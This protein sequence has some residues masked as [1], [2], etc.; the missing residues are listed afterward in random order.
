MFLKKHFFLISEFDV[1]KDRRI[2]LERLGPRLPINK[3]K[4]K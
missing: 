2:F 4:K 1:F 3:K